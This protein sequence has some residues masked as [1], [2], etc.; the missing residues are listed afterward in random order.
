[1]D[2]E[3]LG[4]TPDVIEEVRSSE[5]VRLPFAKRA[6]PQH[7]GPGMPAKDHVLRGAGPRC[8]S[9]GGSLLMRHRIALPG[10]VAMD[11]RDIVQNLCVL[12]AYVFI[13][14]VLIL[15]GGPQHSVLAD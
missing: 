3:S 4:R 5:S 10:V 6:S 2:N 12:V 9:P 7:G 8:L 13:M 11:W 15:I 14:W 1:M